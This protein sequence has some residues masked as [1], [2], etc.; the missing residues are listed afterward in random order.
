MLV[1][2][3]P[4]DSK[5]DLKFKLGDFGSSVFCVLH[6]DKE[7]YLQ[8]YPGTR[9]YGLFHAAELGNHMLTNLGAPECY[10]WDPFSETSLPSRQV[11]PHADLWSYGAIA[12]ELATWTMCGG[13]RSVLT[14]RNSR[15]TAHQLNRNFEDTDCFHDG[16]KLLESVKE[17]H[18]FLLY[19]RDPRDATA[20]VIDLIV[21]DMLQ[22]V[23]ED[24][25]DPRTLLLKADTVLSNVRNAIDAELNSRTASESQQREQIE[26]IVDTRNPLP[27]A[28]SV[29]RRKPT[30]MT[31]DPNLVP[32]KQIHGR[33]SAGRA[34]RTAFDPISTERNHTKP[35]SNVFSSNPMFYNEQ[36][37]PGPSSPTRRAPVTRATADDQDF[38]TGT[39]PSKPRHCPSSSSR[40]KPMGPIQTKTRI[41]NHHR[42]ETHWM[43]SAVHH[44]Q[45]RDGLGVAAITDPSENSLRL[46]FFNGGEGDRQISDT[47]PPRDMR[48]RPKIYKPLITYGS[49]GPARSP[50]LVEE[51]TSWTDT[52]RSQDHPFLEEP[53]SLDTGMEPEWSRELGSQHGPRYS[54]EYTRS[55]SSASND[56]GPSVAGR[57]TPENNSSA[58]AVPYLSVDEAEAWIKFEENR[59]SLRRLGHRRPS[60][61]RNLDCEKLSQLEDRDFVSNMFIV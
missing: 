35:N 42:Q 30:P 25:T 59:F 48:E 27:R 16:I 13:F 29:P 24:R 40:Q 15:K 9:T 26:R 57:S 5:Y 14:Y 53:D 47:L 34:P 28:V 51:P 61:T 20:A 49:P 8:N 54:K 12:S 36:F 33:P 4:T 22:D 39:T 50:G 52:V 23:P 17:Q 38:S 2:P 3:G 55:E 37:A 45:L 21:H 19:N 43:S 58:K 18:Q 7:T 32:S 56:Q 11:L 1:F 44:G 6:D 46:R 10:N 31:E 41:N 60:K